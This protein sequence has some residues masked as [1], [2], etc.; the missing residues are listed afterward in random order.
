MRNLIFFSLFNIA[1]MITVPSGIS[2]ANMQA[3]TQ[4]QEI[5]HFNQQMQAEID[6]AEKRVAEIQKQLTSNTTSPAYIDKV[7]FQNAITMLEVKKTL[8]NNFM[9]SPLLKSQAV[10]DTLLEVLKKDLI[11]ESDLAYLQSV[12]EQERANQAQQAQSQQVQPVQPAQPAQQVQPTPQPTPA[13]PQVQ[14]YP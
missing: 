7:A 14:N 5:D 9:N 8:R 3:T 1:L 10:R 11:T 12:A 6:A 4:N 2:A 13:T